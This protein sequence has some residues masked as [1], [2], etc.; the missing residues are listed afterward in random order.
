MSIAMPK[1]DAATLAKRDAIIAALRRIVPGEGVIDD[2][3]GLRPWESDGLTAYRQ[4]PMV[5]VLQWCAS[6]KVTEAPMQLLARAGYVVKIPSGSHLCC[7]SAGTYNILQPEISNRLGRRKA[8]AIAN[9]YAGCDRDWKRRLRHPDCPLFRH[10][11]GP[12]GRASRLGDR[13][14]PACRPQPSRYGVTT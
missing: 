11:R 4:V 14:S 5:V 3:D 13:W 12:H 10:T 8:D 6:E 7:G 1:P 9:L 2:P